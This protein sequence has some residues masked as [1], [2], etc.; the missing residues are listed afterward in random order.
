MISSGFS[1]VHSFAF[2]VS[3]R[4]SSERS[5]RV[6]VTGSDQPAYDLDPKEPVGVRLCSEGR[7]AIVPVPRLTGS[8]FDPR[9]L[10]WDFS[11]PHTQKLE[12]AQRIAKMK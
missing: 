1:L 5:Q 7:V 3:H 10:F 6:N 2:F 9:I 11:V 12:W 8:H 4:Q